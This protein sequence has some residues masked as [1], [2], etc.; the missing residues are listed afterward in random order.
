ME[1]TD[2]P[3]DLHRQRLILQDANDLKLIQEL[4]KNTAE[5]EQL[6]GQLFDPS[7]RRTLN[8]DDLLWL[9]FQFSVYSGA[10]HRANE[11][12]AKINSEIE[13]LSVDPPA[14]ESD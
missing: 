3:D 2:N 9:E 13:Q 1:R 8:S 7:K 6:F 11:A 10:V 4:D 14:S 12:N 5:A